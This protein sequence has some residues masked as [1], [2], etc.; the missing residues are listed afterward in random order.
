L[1]F[2]RW[3]IN[4]C[5]LQYIEK[6]IEDIEQDMNGCYRAIYNMNGARRSSS[7]NV[8]PDSNNSESTSSSRRRRHEL[9]I[10]ATKTLSKSNVKVVMTFD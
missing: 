10:C 8:S 7:N 9:S 3:A 4:E 6:H 1:N 2:F 5:I